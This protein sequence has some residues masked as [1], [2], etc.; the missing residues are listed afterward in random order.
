MKWELGAWVSVVTAYAR[1]VFGRDDDRAQECVCIAWRR[2]WRPVPYHPR[3]A[4]YFASRTVMTGRA[5]VNT[6]P[7]GKSGDVFA[8]GNVYRCGAMGEYPDPRR[9]PLAELIHREH[10][11]ELRRRRSELAQKRGLA[12]AFARWHGNSGPRDTSNGEGG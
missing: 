7:I 4:A 6:H 2:Y 3:V 5:F 8:R 10:F 11:E 1:R 12:G 9:G